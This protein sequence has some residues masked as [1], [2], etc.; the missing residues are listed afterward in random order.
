VADAEIVV[1]PYPGEAGAIGAAL[2]AGD[3]LKSGATTRFRGYDVIESLD[4]SSTTNQHTTCKWC[5]VDCKRTFIDVALPDGKGRPWSKVPLAAG[6]ERVIS[7]N[8]C[9]KGLLEDVNEM[10]VVKKN[11][12]A[13]KNDHP[14]T[15]EVVRQTAFRRATIA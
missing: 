2:C 9:P 4:Y 5:P 10:L 13:V 14:N 15:A 7:G 1:H 8:S 3:W 6:W 11:L 12:E